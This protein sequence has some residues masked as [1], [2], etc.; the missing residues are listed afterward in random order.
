MNVLLNVPWDNLGGVCNV[1][2]AVGLHLRNQGH[3]VWLLLPGESNDPQEATSRVGLPVFRL[4]LRPSRVEGA[5]LKSALGYRVHLQQATRTLRTLLGDLK[6]EVVNI[7]FPHDG[8]RYFAGLSRQGLVK[9]VTS[10]HGADLL[11]YPA[12]PS[13]KHNGVSIVLSS[14]ESI[15]A[16][17]RSF[18]ESAARKWPL[19]KSKRIDVIPNGIDPLELGYS[20]NT[21]WT[22]AQPPYILSVATLVPYKGVD[23]IIRAFGLIAREVP[24]VR[25]KLVSG[26]PAYGQLLALA[27]ELEVAER[28]DFIGPVDR[29]R[30][31]D[32]IRGCTLFVL[33]SRSDSESF[34]IAAAE[35][36]A[37]DRA[38][39]VSDVGA[40]P[41]IVHHE[42]TG[43]LVPPGDAEAL[44]IA[45][46]R[47]LSD[48]PLR[49]RLGTAAGEKVRREYSWSRTGAMYEAL[50]QSVVGT[51]AR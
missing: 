1:V 27:S 47:A 29:K 17:S 25:L 8:S 23:V 13:L 21:E 48:R 4:N 39:I 46:R 33:A 19:L 22:E 24:G 6:V 43:L 31:A 45:M 30:V 9:L 37:V 42:E 35:A 49:E 15:V 7:H 36:M 44:A 18:V 3:A 28:I 41:E 20:A 38:V 51:G 26:G 16:P 12:E 10:I 40:L 2:N 5:R 14:S 34:G 11:P 32:V 50:F